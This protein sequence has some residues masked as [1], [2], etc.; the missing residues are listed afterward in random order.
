MKKVAYEQMT[1]EVMNQY[2]LELHGSQ[3][4]NAILNYIF[5][6]DQLV[7]DTL[8]SIDPFKNPTDLARSQ[9]RREGL[10]DLRDHV[11]M[12]KKHSLEEV[13]ETK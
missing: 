11:E 8:H 6:R 12:L 1:D 7:T 3:I 9:G 2:L 10:F 13:K 4:Y 5:K